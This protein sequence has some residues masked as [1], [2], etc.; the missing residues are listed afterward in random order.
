M[1]SV[2]RIANV[3][4]F[5]LSLALSLTPVGAASVTAGNRS[6][7]SDDAV[8]ADLAQQHGLLVQRIDDMPA[9]VHAG[10]SPFRAL[11]RREVSEYQHRIVDLNPAGCTGDGCDENRNTVVEASRVLDQDKKW[12][13][14]KKGKSFDEGC[15]DRDSDGCCLVE[16]DESGKGNSDESEA[17]KKKAQEK[18]E[19]KSEADKK[20]KEKKEVHAEKKKEEAE[21]A[22]QTKTKVDKN[23]GDDGDSSSNEPK[24]EPLEDKKERKKG[25]GANKPDDEQKNRTSD[26]GDKTPGIKKDRDNKSDLPDKSKPSEGE[27]KRKEG[28]DMAEAD[29]GGKLGTSGETKDDE[30]YNK[31]SKPKV[32]KNG[33]EKKKVEKYNK[34]SKPKV[35]KNSIEKKKVRPSTVSFSI[36]IYVSTSH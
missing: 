21:A 32:E 33:I 16:D 14:K 22:K 7:Q 2:L 24:N 26:N 11:G 30:K 31:S 35:E 3:A 4:C 17:A 34:S 8:V 19:A 5:V 18:K 6:H 10:P 29:G 23:R 25:T 12:V 27:D 9:I 28:T 20:A 36:V 1:K 15:E 13:C